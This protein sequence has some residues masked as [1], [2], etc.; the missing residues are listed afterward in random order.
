[1][2][3]KSAFTF[4]LKTES[5]DTTPPQGLQFGGVVGRKKPSKK[6][7]PNK[8]LKSSWF[9]PTEKTEIPYL[10]GGWTNPSEKYAQVKLYHLPR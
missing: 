6:Q 3:P 7:V 10:V 1:M 4:T 2:P 9:H 5:S 8:S